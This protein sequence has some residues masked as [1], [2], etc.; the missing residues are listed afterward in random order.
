MFFHMVWFILFGVL[1]WETSF[2]LVEVLQQPIRN[3]HHKV[4]RANTRSKMDHIMWKSMKN[5]A[6][7]WCRSLCAFLFQATCAFGKMW[8]FSSL[9]YPIFGSSHL[10]SHQNG[11]QAGILAWTDELE[12]QVSSY[13]LPKV[14]KHRTIL[15]AQVR[16]QVRLLW[17]LLQKMRHR[18]MDIARQHAMW[19]LQVR[20]RRFIKKPFFHKKPLEFLKMYSK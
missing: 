12:F 4:F 20:S 10:T 6:Q 8:M 18:W 3:F 16:M 13:N 9:H 17:L 5:W 14:Y 11:V 19:F 15:L 2:S 7:K 1:G